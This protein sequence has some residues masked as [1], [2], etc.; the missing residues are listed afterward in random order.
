MSGTRS[1]N[2]E[3]PVELRRY[4]HRNRYSLPSYFIR[5]RYGMPISTQT[6]EETVSQVISRRMI[7]RQQMRWSRN[8]AQHCS[9]CAPQLLNGSR[10]AE[11]PTLGSAVRP[12]A[13]SP[14]SHTPHQS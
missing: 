3:A 10:E 5:Q 9:R 6:T 8:D 14:F 12:G 4:L 2:S 1:V 11:S 7:K 13:L